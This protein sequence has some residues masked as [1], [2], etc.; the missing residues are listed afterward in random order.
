[1]DWNVVR[2]LSAISEADTGDCR[3]VLAAG[4]PSAGR[5]AFCG[6]CVKT[7]I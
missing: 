3:L 1:M 2:A 7:L 5:M 6:A 4:P